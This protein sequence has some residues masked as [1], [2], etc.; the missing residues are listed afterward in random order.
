[1]NVLIIEDEHFS[2]A[3]L[4][5]MLLALRPNFKILSILDSVEDSIAWLAENN[6]P[7]LIF[8]D[9][10]LGDGLCFEIFK[11]YAL[12]C[13][14]I[15]TTAYNEYMLQ[16]FETNGISYLL[17][18]VEMKSLEAALFKV[19]KLLGIKDKTSF[20]IGRLNDILNLKNTSYRSSILIQYKAKKIPIAVSS[21]A[22][23]MVQNTITYLVTNDGISYTL[24]QRLDEIEKSLDPQWFYRANRQFLISFKAIDS[25]E[26]YFA[27]KTLVHLKVA[28]PEAVIV[29]KPKSSSFLN[30]LENH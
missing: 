26:E 11:D 25:V 27:R 8:S 28:T 12:S 6:E 22:Y 10:Q 16:A 14:I 18:P 15:F 20:D 29:S 4:K 9:I 24:Y 7:D 3:D 19:E 1:M 23:F 13:P 5:Q 17:K 30:W 21:I 2:A